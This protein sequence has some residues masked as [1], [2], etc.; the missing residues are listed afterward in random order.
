LDYAAD[1]LHPRGP[2]RGV[3]R[4]LAAGGLL[5]LVA[6]IVQ[7]LAIAVHNYPDLDLSRRWGVHDY[8]L[9]LLSQPLPAESSVVGL[10]GEMTLLRYFQ[11]TIGLR[12]DVETVA[13]DDEGARREAVQAALDEGRAVYI[14]RPLPGLTDQ[15]ALGAVTGLIDVAGDMEAL[16]RVH[17]PDDPAP[18]PP[19]EVNLELVPGLRLLG[20]GVVEHRGHW[21]AWV[22]LRLWWQ[23]QAGLQQ[24]LKVSA[25][26]VDTAGQVVAATDAEPVSGAYPTTAW[27]P[28]EQVADAYEI[29][30]PAGLPPGE[31]TPLLILYEPATGLERGRAELPPIHLEGNP[32]RPPRRAL[33][34]SVARPVYALFGDVELLGF[35]PPNPEVS[36]RPGE[37]LLLPLLWQARG[38]PAGRLQ[39]SLWLEGRQRYSVAQ[40]PLG[41]L[42]P[43]DRWR[44]GQTVRQ[45]LSVQVPD[46][47]PDGVY[48]L[49][50]RVTRDGKPVPWGR[51]LV[52]LGGDLDLGSLEI[53]R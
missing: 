35:T 8:G 7:P 1:L 15:V 2:S 46:G 30:V 11:R 39:L 22:R 44:D 6:A 21:Q 12:P 49:K 24:P 36:I 23:A 26:L 20:F 19:N 13:A 42:F 41:G 9:Y 47:V 17:R 27:R 3:R 25:R 51:G 45:V 10:L 29:P 33:E 4:L 31:Y 18:A 48:R 5:L 53:S 38:Q 34:A 43:A 52:P 32:L 50:M 40:V 28:G 14:T 16:L 37:D